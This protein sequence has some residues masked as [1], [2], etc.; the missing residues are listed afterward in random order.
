MM[1]TR[2]TVLPDSMPLS[3]ANGGIYTNGVKNPTSNIE[4][5][6]FHNYQFNLFKYIKKLI[7]Y[8]SH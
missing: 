5:I 2:I 3:S 6:K 8:L 1:E 4:L 7:V